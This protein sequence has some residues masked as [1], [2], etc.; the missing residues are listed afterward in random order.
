MASRLAAVGEVE[1]QQRR[2][3]ADGSN[4]IV[5]FFQPAL[6]ARGQHDMGAEPGQL[7]RRRLANAAA[8]AGDQRHVI[9]QRQ[10]AQCASVSRL[11]WRSA[12]S[13]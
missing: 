6:G 2:N 12:L 10:H 3:T 5:G 1:R 9:G 13:I 8:G 7:D 4:R 11:S